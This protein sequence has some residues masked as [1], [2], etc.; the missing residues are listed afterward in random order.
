MRKTARANETIDNHSAGG[1]SRK[2]PPHIGSGIP[3][4]GDL[5]RLARLRSRKAVAGDDADGAISQ[6]G[7]KPDHASDAA[8][9]AMETGITRGLSLVS[10]GFSDRK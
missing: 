6:R 5:L 10:G 8:R 1:A 4:I 2:V 3:F 9:T 7:R